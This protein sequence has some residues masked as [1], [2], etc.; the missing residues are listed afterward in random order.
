MTAGARSQSLLSLRRCATG[1]SGPIS[2][3]AGTREIGE[4]DVQYR[5]WCGHFEAEH[6]PS[7]GCAG[8]DAGGKPVETIEHNYEPDE[9]WPEP[10]TEED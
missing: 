1:W 10:D 9:D 6:T 7:I 4:I 2:A 3:R 5:C 8:C